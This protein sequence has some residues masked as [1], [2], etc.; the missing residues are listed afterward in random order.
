M[1]EKTKV[2]D[3]IGCGFT[4]L[5]GLLVFGGFCVFMFWLCMQIFGWELQAMK[6]KEDNTNTVFWVIIVGIVIWM[7]MGGILRCAGIKSG[8]MLNSPVEYR[9]TDRIY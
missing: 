2:K 9:H 5:I 7:L 4:S 6:D 3:F 1:E 8:D